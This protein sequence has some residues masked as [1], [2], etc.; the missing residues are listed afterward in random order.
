MWAWAR[1]CRLK[2]YTT[3]YCQTE[4]MSPHKTSTDYR[5]KK[6]NDTMDIR[7]TRL[8]TN[9]RHANQHD[10]SSGNSNL[11]PMTMLNAFGTQVGGPEPWDTVTTS[12]HSVGDHPADEPNN[13]VQNK[14]IH[15]SIEGSQC[16]T[17]GGAVMVGLPGVE[18]QPTFGHPLNVERP[19]VGLRGTTAYTRTLLSR[20][21]H[22]SIPH[23]QEPLQ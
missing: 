14:L 6:I 7:N 13:C 10:G 11:Q 19:L 17:R 22:R 12:T 18:T 4:P 5:S 21:R 23:P 16:Y 1:T 3:D 15:P 8:R 2:L 20:T 9:S